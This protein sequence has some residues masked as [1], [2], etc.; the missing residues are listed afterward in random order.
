MVRYHGNYCGPN[1][2][3]GRDQPSV[4]SDIPAVDS[5]DE[6]CKDHDES[7]AKNQNLLEADLLFAKK[8]IGYGLKRTTA[9]LLV[10]GQ[11]VLRKFLPSA[12]NSRLRGRG[13]KMKPDLQVEEIDFEIIGNPNEGTSGKPKMNRSKVR[14]IAPHRDFTSSMDVEIQPR[15]TLRESKMSS[16]K[17]NGKKNTT[18]NVNRVS[19]NANSTGTKGV[20]NNLAVNSMQTFIKSTPIRTLHAGRHSETVAGVVFLSSL[21]TS[22]KTESS[23]DDL[24]LQALVQLNPGNFGSSILSNVSKFYECF[25][26]T[27]LR[28]HYLTASATTTAGTV[29]ISHQRDPLNE[30]PS[31]G[32]TSTNLYTALFARENT[33]MGP[34]WE[35]S[36]MDIPLVHKADEWFYTDSK[37]GHTINELYQ[38]YILAYSDQESGTPGRLMLEFQ[39]EFQNRAVEIGP[40]VPRAIAQKVSLTVSTATAGDVAGITGS[41]P[42]IADETI[43]CF[44]LDPGAS[45]YG[46]GADLDDVFTTY[47]GEHYH[48][49]YGAPIFITQTSDGNNSAFYLTIEA[50]IGRAQPLK[51]K[52]TT[53]TTSTLIGIG[54]QV[55]QDLLE[56][57][58]L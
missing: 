8:N 18:R 15:G 27:R 31:R 2:S 1:W 12:A 48:M 7:Y 45:T 49:G 14:P 53:T 43:W 5:F 35:N 33:I 54:Y 55:V 36:Y 9:G 29:V 3:A 28:V 26:F 22:S 41:S 4:V 34:I 24:A 37:Y 19:K 58:G 11:G 30:I 40:N 16:K 13:R 57:T 10:G 25:K 20:S 42:G 44:Y 52:N 32:Y 39:V 6:T 38:G 23:L 17:K 51:M 46:T 56:V 21:S 47:A 50:A